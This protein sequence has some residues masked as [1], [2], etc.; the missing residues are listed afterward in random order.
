MGGI[1]TKRNGNEVVVLRRTTKSSERSLEASHTTVTRRDIVKEEQNSISSLHVGSRNANR[2]NNIP[3]VG[4]EVDGVESY[5]EDMQRAIEAS[6]KDSQRSPDDVDDGRAGAGSHEKV[7][8]QC[9]PVVASGLGGCAWVDNSEF[10]G[11]RAKQF[12]RT[13]DVPPARFRPHSIH[14][15]QSVGSNNPG[16]RRIRSS[17]SG[18]SRKVRHASED[19]KEMVKDLH[20]RFKHQQRGGE[21]R[22][23]LS[24]EHFNEHFHSCR[25]SCAGAAPIW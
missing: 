14:C 1:P 20:I 16:G 15:V 8:P 21:F 24:N 3:N 11:P 18:S 19:R 23:N 2:Q 7:I 4:G 6:L 17:R 25:D 9:P 22:A 13:H 12:V 10:L 5:E